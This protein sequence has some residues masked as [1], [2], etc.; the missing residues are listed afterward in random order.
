MTGAGDGGRLA[1][2]FQAARAYSEH[3]A[4]IHLRSRQEIAALLDGWD[5]VE[6]GLVPIPDWRPDQAPAGPA[7]AH[8][9]GLAVVACTPRTA[10]SRGDRI[11][12][13]GQAGDMPRP[14]AAHDATRAGRPPIVGR[15]RARRRGV[16]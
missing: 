15:E 5:P 11:R 7:S 2:T 9:H 12:A 6:P 10:T 3:I 4:P 1:G 14:R 16:R 13:M 8:R